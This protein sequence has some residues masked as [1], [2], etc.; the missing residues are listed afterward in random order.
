MR[1]VVH[2]NGVGVGAGEFADNT[3][4]MAGG[5]CR[6]RSSILRIYQSKS[7]SSF[8]SSKLVV[9]VMQLVFLSTLCTSLCSGG[10]IGDSSGDRLRAGT[11]IFEI[12]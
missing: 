8:G 12:F 10:E 7:L 4:V 1:E 6:N 2:Q 5:S 11:Y 3:R 9:I